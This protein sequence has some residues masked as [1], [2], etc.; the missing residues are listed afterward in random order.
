MSAIIRYPEIGN[1]A[2][3]IDKG[4]PI[5]VLLTQLQA[6]YF[7]RHLEMMC[8]VQKLKGMPAFLD[9]LKFGALQA[10]ILFR[11]PRI[12]ELGFYYDIDRDTLKRILFRDHDQ[13]VVVTFVPR[14]IVSN[15]AANDPNTL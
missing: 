7:K 12:L 13:H 10:A 15:S 5:E 4:K 8:K 14:E 11:C 6:R 2:A 3:H 9:S 1:A